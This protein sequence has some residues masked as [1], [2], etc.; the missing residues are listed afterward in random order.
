VTRAA[1]LAITVLVA[2]LAA[3]VGMA[4]RADTA[5]IA[6]S[7]D[8]P[9]TNPAHESSL[10]VLASKI[11][12]VIAK[13]PVTIRCEGDTDWVKLVAQSGGDPSSELGYVA[14]TTTNGVV[15]SISNFAEMAGGRVCLPLK[16]FA[17]AL[18]KPTKCK[19]LVPRTTFSYVTRRV[20]VK[21]TIVVAGKRQV[22]TTWV[23][24]RIRV[25]I[26]SI[27]LGPPI[28]CY[29][30]SKPTELVPL[31]FWSEYNVYATAIL[32]LAHESIHLGGIMPGTRLPNGVYVG[33]PLG[34][35]KA[36][37]YGIQWMPYVAQQLGDT[38]DD[39]QAIAQYFYSVIYPQFAT[40]SLAEYWSADCKAGGALD[41]KLPG[42]APWSSP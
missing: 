19:S 40:S 16:R 39:A 34:E 33:D 1:R 8:L 32:S 2:L 13:R 9:W 28:A 17:V 24:K 3:Q 42:P 38:A 27:V 22:K 10:E 26:V 20:P 15:T 36:Q 11:A 21:K 4:A 31:S 12:S 35:A 30:S 5:P 7:P 37:C 6:D 41:L 29:Q 25:K 14:A 18:T 23:R